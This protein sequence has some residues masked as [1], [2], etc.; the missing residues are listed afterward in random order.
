MNN[1]T[2]T[3]AALEVLKAAAAQV[4]AIKKNAAPAV[5]FGSLDMAEFEGVHKLAE[6]LKELQ[7][8]FA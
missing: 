7:K 8:K 2:P 1:N 4:E 3:T 6:A 5:F